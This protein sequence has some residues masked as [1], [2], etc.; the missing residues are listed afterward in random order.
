MSV[1]VQQPHREV[2]VLCLGMSRTGTMSLRAAFSQLGYQGVYHYRVP[3]IEKPSHSD[4]WLKALRT[5]YEEHGTVTRRDFDTVYDDYEVITDSPS[6]FFCRELLDAYPDAKVILQTRPMDIW[7]KSHVANIWSFND[8][9]YGYT[10]NPYRVLFQ[11]L[12][13]S[14]PF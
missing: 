6:V 14:G 8:E 10:W 7:F 1:S 9:Y 13:P 11:W 12:R 5:K 3:A 4:F 2:R